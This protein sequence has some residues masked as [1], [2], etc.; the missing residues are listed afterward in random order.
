MAFC[1][2][3]HLKFLLLGGKKISE[4]ETSLSYVESSRQAKHLISKL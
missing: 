2:D 4:F 3:M 1:S